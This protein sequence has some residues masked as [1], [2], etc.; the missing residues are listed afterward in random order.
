MYNFKTKLEDN[1]ISWTSPNKQLCLNDD[2]D[3]NVTC[4]AWIEWQMSIDVRES[5]VKST[6]I[7]ITDVKVLV[8][9][10]Y[11]DDDDSLIRG[12][13]EISN[14]IYKLEDNLKFKGGSLEPDNVHIDFNKLK[15]RVE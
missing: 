3:V 6:D 13:F 9:Y 5:G 15:I 2:I 14:S 10:E 8:E 1:C 12:S 7:C 4:T 11:F